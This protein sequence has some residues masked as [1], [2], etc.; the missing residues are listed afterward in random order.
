MCSAEVIEIANL[1]G[2]FVWKDKPDLRDHGNEVKTVLIQTT[3]AP[4]DHLVIRNAILQSDMMS[5]ET[6]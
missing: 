6:I 1:E 3:Y 2:H 5:R 4:I